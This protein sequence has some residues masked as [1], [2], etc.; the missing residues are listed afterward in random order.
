MKDGLPA[1]WNNNMI[2]FA[3]VEGFEVRRVYACEQRWWA[4]CFIFCSDGRISD[5]EFC[6]NDRGVDEN[7]NVYHGLKRAKYKEACVK[8]SDGIDLRVGCHDIVIENVYGFTEDDTVALTALT[9]ALEKNFWVEGLSTDICNVEIRNVSSS[10]YCS[11]VRLLNQGEHKLHDIYIEGVF[12]TSA[13]SPH[14]DRGGCGVRIGDGTHMYGTRPSTADET[15]N[16]VVRNVRSRA[17][18]AMSLHGDMKNIVIEN[19]EIFD[20]GGEIED[21]RQ[22]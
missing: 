3:N 5:V 9:G 6:S 14:M 8:N 16:I 1:I 13:N 7:G 20:G 19:V 11:N 18:R 22:S 17:R 12:D 4:F 21:L 10:A 15:Y 2:L